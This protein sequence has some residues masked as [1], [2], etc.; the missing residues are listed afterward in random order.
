MFHVEQTMIDERAANLWTPGQQQLRFWAYPLDWKQL[1]DLGPLR[2]R[3]SIQSYFQLR[4]CPPHPQKMFNIFRRCPK[5]GGQGRVLLAFPDQGCCFP[6]AKTPSPCQQVD[7]FQQSG[8]A[9]TIASGNNIYPFSGKQRRTF[10][11]SQV[12]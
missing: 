8:L 10:Y 12:V 11:D 7:R 3:F 4:T 1:Q 6:V 9:T 2:S 5:P